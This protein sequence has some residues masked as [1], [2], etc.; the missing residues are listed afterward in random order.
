MRR[1]VAVF[2]VLLCMQISKTRS[3]AFEQVTILP[4][5]MLQNFTHKVEKSTNLCEFSRKIQTRKNA[6]CL[7]KSTVCVHVW[8]PH[9]CICVVRKLTHKTP[10]PFDWL[11]SKHGGID[12]HNHLT[13]ISLWLIVV[14]TFHVIGSEVPWLVNRLTNKQVRHVNSPE[15]VTSVS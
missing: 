9:S 6:R 8:R 7:L 14:T 1:S 4:V 10:T 2:S 5:T 13:K 11:A 12:S 15:D 3:V